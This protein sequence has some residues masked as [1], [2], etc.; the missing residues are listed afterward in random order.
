MVVNTTLHARAQ[1]LEDQATA[2]RDELAGIYADL[3]EDD[4]DS[5]MA[6]MAERFRAERDAAIRENIG[7]K[8]QLATRNGEYEARF[9]AMESRF[10]DMRQAIGSVL[11]NPRTPRDHVQSVLLQV[12]EKVRDFTP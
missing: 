1:A 3:A 6:R 10:Y 11:N 2:I 9:R 8:S 7:L 5:F 12:H 4:G